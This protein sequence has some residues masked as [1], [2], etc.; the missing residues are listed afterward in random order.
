[1]KIKNIFI[2]ALGA[3]TLWSC[4]PKEFNLTSPV[5]EI[6]IADSAVSDSLTIGG[7]DGTC[8]VAYAPQWMEATVTDSVVVFK[9]QPNTDTVPRVDSLVVAC[10]ASKI[11]IPVRQANKA[12]RLE[13]PKNTKLS[14]AKEGGEEF[15]N[16]DTDGSVTV[17]AFEGVTATYADGKLAVKANPNTGDDPI[18]GTLKLTAGDFTQEIPVTVKGKTCPTCNGTG[19]VK[20]KSCG[21]QGYSF[22]MNPSPGI[23]GCKSC[24]GKGYSYRVEGPDYRQG[25]GKQP[26]PTCGG[27]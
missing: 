11:N 3:A 12:T 24:G 16:V 7:S 21:G 4:G 19:K 2:A 22:K 13:I 25:S 18:K 5:A 1:M 8:T 23:Y 10:G 9:A 20:C 15:V 26:C 14:F 27:K 6:S 17:E